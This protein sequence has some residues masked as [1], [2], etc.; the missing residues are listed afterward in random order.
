MINAELN[1]IGSEPPRQACPEEIPFRIIYTRKGQEIFVDTGDFDWLSSFRWHL[2]HGYATRRSHPKSDVRILM[3]RLLLQV[4]DTKVQVDHLRI[5]TISQNQCNVGLQPNNKSGY[6]GVWFDKTAYVK[7][8][9]M[10]VTKNR[11]VHNG[12]YYL[13][14][15]DAAIARDKLALELHGEFANLNFPELRNASA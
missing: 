10:C 12:K 14:A 5:C 3:H 6:K 8:Y 1:L 15:R 4:T 9:T 2:H 13:T 11:K 7:K